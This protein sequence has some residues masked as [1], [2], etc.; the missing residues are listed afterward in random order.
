LLLDTSEAETEPREVDP[1]TAFNLE[2]RS[3]A[4]FRWPIEVQ[5]V[6]AEAMGKDGGKKG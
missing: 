3:L 1:K 2:G 5:E 4:L 6:V